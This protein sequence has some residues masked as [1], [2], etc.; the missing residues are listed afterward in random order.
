MH[1]A[2]VAPRRSRRLG[3]SL[4]QGEETGEPGVLSF[5]APL[6]MGTASVRD[7]YCLAHQGTFCT[8]CSEQ[9]PVEDAIQVVDGKPVIDEA[10]CTGCGVCQHVCPAPYNA[11]LILPAQRGAGGAPPDATPDA[12]QP[13]TFDWRRAYL[14]D[15]SLDPPSDGSLTPR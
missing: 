12:T 8:V 5:N 2:A 10:I 4:I 11:I 13:D 6:K 3:W 1:D 7:P 15:R 9:C 14:G